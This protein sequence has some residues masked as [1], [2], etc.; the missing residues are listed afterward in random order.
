MGTTT[1]STTTTTTSTSTTT[2]T[3]TYEESLFVACDDHTKVFLDGIQFTDSS[4]SKWDETSEISLPFNAKVIAIS[5]INSKGH[6][7][8]KASTSYGIVTDATWRCSN[9]EEDNWMMTDF[10]DSTWE[11]AK[12]ENLHVNGLSRPQLSENAQWIWSQSGHTKAYCRKIIS[13][14]S[15]FNPGTTRTTTTTT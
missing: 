9:V 13:Q 7:G 5:C 8:I 6:Y 14:G 11:F 15:T 1:T 4:M 2:T 10:D 3:T 12:T